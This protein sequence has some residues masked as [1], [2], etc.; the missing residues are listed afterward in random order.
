M[1]SPF[2]RCPSSVL[3]HFVNKFLLSLQDRFM[4]PAFRNRGPIQNWNA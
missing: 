3:T 1:T 2:R 4:L